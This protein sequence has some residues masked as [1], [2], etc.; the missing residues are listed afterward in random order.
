MLKGLSTTYETIYLAVTTF[1]RCTGNI[2]LEHTVVT[3]NDGGDA[4]LML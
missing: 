3:T 4:V 2:D 1:L